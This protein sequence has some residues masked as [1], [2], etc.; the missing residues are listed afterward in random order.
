MKYINCFLG[1]DG[2]V[3]RRMLIKKPETLLGWILY[4]FPPEYNSEIILSKKEAIT[5]HGKSYN[6][7][8]Y[9]VETAE[10]VRIPVR[11]K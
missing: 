3:H 6:P 7:Q 8:G 5:L 9:Y 4:L 1:E 10:G 11:I 2:K